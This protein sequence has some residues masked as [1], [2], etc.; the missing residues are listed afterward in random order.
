MCTLKRG[1]L[2]EAPASPVVPFSRRISL[3]RLSNALQTTR[4]HSTASS[5]SPAS[6][7]DL[8]SPPT[9]ALAAC[10]LPSHDST[11][12]RRPKTHHG[13]SPA[14]AEAGSESQGFED[15]SPVLTRHGEAVRS[16]PAERRSTAA[17][18]P[19]IEGPGEVFK[20]AEEAG[21]RRAK[22]SGVPGTPPFGQL[23]SSRRSNTHGG[24]SL[25]RCGLVSRKPRPPKQRK[26]KTNTAPVRE[27]DPR[28][29]FEESGRV[30]G[31]KMV[32]QRHALGRGL[33]TER[34]QKSGRILSKNG[35]ALHRGLVITNSVRAEL[36]NPM[37][38]R[39]KLLR[40]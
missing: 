28:R 5:V 31:G 10:C 18:R 12:R 22:L 36:L 9:L 25:T 17:A 13:I 38:H 26:A 19:R 15:S 8:S 37:S 39:F 24:R 21:E 14:Q 16:E 1:F 32:P 20:E 4:R 6:D 33:A 3:L 35:V 30:Q 7:L 34:D 27:H 11:L 23:A 40:R 2:R 29:N